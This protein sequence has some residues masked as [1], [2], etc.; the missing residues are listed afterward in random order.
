VEPSTSSSDTSTTARRNFL[1]GIASIVIGGLISL[2]PIVSGLLF[3][4]DPILRRRSNFKGGDADGFLS[5]PNL[6][7]SDLPD[8]GTPVRFE[9]RADKVDAWNESKNQTIGTVYIR[10]MPGD[11]ILVFNDTCPHLG[12]KVEYQE[13]KQSF[14]CPCH[15]S[16]FSLDGEPTN[17]IPPRKLDALESKIDSAGRVWIKYQ[18]F[19]CGVEQQKAV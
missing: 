14:L 2:T 10:K 6:S 4:L 7:L 15:S 1:S 8:D 16:A 12:C 9:L 13:G 17:K 11:Q 5:V 3:F 18:D 19:Q